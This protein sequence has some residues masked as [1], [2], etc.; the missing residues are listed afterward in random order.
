LEGI[1]TQ[2]LRDRLEIVVIDS[3]STDGS[4]DLLAKY[5][6]RVHRI[7]ARAFNHGETRNLGVRLAQGEFVA[8]TVQDARPV[9]DRW[10]ER[11][12]KHFDDPMVA[13]VCGQ[14]VVP[15]ELDK[16]PLQWF[17]PYS[18]PVPRKIQFPNPAEFKQ[19]PPVEQVAMCG[20]D[21]VN[22]MYRR[23]ALLE[24]PFRCVNFSEDGIWARDA[25]LHGH[26]LVYDYSA[27]VYH[28]HHENF[29]FHFRRRYTILYHWHR[30]FHFVQTPSWVLPELAR[31]IYRISRRKYCPERRAHWLAFN[32]RLRLADWLAG[33][34]FWLTAKTGGS[35]AVEKRHRR[36]CATAPQPIPSASMQQMYG[37]H[38]PAVSA[39]PPAMRAERANAER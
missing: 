18:Q 5:P 32:A 9:D 37:A 23:S 2:T 6:A 39:G 38:E 30:Y 21:D 13:G 27:R 26:A 31:C 20:W 34:S 35:S 22:A 8:M 25:L 24:V 29:G 16:N 7:D 14:Q 17:R 12:M 28:Y 11:M 4:L 36:F 15:H 33:W 1:L 19:L 10:L 3:G